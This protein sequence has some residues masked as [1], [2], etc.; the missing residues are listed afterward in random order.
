MSR[1]SL[2]QHSW[3]QTGGECDIFLQPES[4]N[5]L[6]NML[7][8]LHEDKVPFF[9]LG[10]GSNSLV[11]DN[12]WK[13]A[14]LSLAAMRELTVEGTQIRCQAG[15]DNTSFADAALQAGLDGAAWM[16]MLPGQM[17]ATVRMN[18]R[19][20]GGEMSRIIRSVRAFDFS[21]N[22]H[23]FSTE[24]Q[25]ET[26]FKGYKNTVFMQQDLVI[27]EVVAE[28]IPGSSEKI[29]QQMDFCEEDRKRK[30]QFDYPSCGCVFK[31]DY[32]SDVSVSSGV[33]LELAGAK[34]IRSNCGAFVSPWHANFIFNSGASAR[35]ILL[36]SCQMRELVWKSFGVWLE[37]EMEILGELSADLHFL[38]SEKRSPEPDRE[39]LREARELFLRQ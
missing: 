9:I 16:H 33:L 36:L 29:R 2:R 25:P 21:G 7:R 10:A 32:S 37:Y 3:F 26:I 34:D 19:C 31:N 5:E 23:E 18:A 13:G 30:H 20:Y 24:F 6:Q 4:E 22:L 28:L 17:G 11:M 39:R 38:V 15:L 27:S 1:C 14:V 35:D 8:W 12:L